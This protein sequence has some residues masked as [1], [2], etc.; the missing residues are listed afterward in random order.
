MFD[1]FFYYNNIGRYILFLKSNLSLYPKNI[2]ILEFSKLV[3]FFNVLNV[4]D[5]NNISILSHIFFLKYYFGIMP[6]FTNYSYKF[7]L[8][9]HYFNFFIQ[10]DFFNKN[11]YYPLYFF[12]NDIYCMINKNNL[13]LNKNFNF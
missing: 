7:K 4:N 13:S 9:L 6:F 11:M 8:N 3:I 12:F 2:D 5:L 10:C 1:Y